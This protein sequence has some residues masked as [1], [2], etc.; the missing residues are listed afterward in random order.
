ML[1]YVQCVQSLMKTST[2][3]WLAQQQHNFM[4]SYLRQFFCGVGS[5][6]VNVDNNRWHTTCKYSLPD[7]RV[8]AYCSICRYRCRHPQL[9]SAADDTCFI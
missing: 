6:R 8:A 5:Q 1:A 2:E 7:A 3:R 4:L 9:P